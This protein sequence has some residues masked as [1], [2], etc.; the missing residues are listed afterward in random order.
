MIFVRNVGIISLHIPEDVNIF[1]HSS[2]FFLPCLFLVTWV[3]TCS[4]TD[5]SYTPPAPPT[6]PCSQVYRRQ[7]RQKYVPNCFLAHMLPAQQ[8]LPYLRAPNQNLIF[9]FLLLVPPLPPLF[10]SMTLMVT[11][12]A[13]GGSIYWSIASL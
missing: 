6:T 12:E 9:V 11:I 7:M 2:L 1:C 8:P 4:G 3:P 10:V 13:E 5:V